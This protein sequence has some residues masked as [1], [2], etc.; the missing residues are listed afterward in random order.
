MSTSQAPKEP[1]ETS[2][3]DACYLMFVLGACYLILVVV[4]MMFVDVRT[5]T[6][7]LVVS[8]VLSRNQCTAID[9]ANGTN[10]VDNC[11][12]LCLDSEAE[13]GTNKNNAC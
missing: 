7:D 1:K 8:M 11:I 5:S 12:V 3:I 9:D 6:D 13:T 2:F 10:F 4:Q